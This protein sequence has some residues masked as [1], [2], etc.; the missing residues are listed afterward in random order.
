MEKYSVKWD[1][2]HMNIAKFM[3]Q[4]KNFCDVTL[5]CDDNQQL[6]AHKIIL[7]AGS[8]FFRDVLTNTKHPHPF[9]YLKG[10]RR[11][12]LQN[13]M[14]FLYHGEASIAHEE[15][16]TF[17]ETAKV[18]QILGIENNYGNDFVDALESYP[19]VKPRPSEIY[20]DKAMLNLVDVQ[21]DSDQQNVYDTEID[22]NVEDLRTMAETNA[23]SLHS[24]DVSDVKNNLVLDANHKLDS[25]TEELIEKKDGLW[26]CKVCGKTSVR[27]NHA[28]NHTEIHLEG[29]NH[30][31][32]V[33]SKSFHT[34]DSLRVHARNNHSDA[35]FMCNVCGKS[36]MSKMSFKNHKPKCGGK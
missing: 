15:L 23:D 30:A 10:V 1:D 22:E 6:D 13:I 4:E 7:S 35:S 18:L 20:E 26:E 2:F 24:E 36:G 11:A 27:K 5:A 17:L 32:T 16:E 34:R 19:D 12:D 31:C 8:Q 21:Q 33:C 29:I 9:I 14:D 28:K 25:K 3:S